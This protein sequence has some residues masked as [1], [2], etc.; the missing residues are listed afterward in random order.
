MITYTDTDS[1]TMLANMYQNGKESLEKAIHKEI[2]KIFNIEPPD[3]INIYV[4][5]WDDEYPGVHM[6]KP[7]EDILNLYEKI[8]QPDINKEIYICGEAYSKKQ[9]W[10]EGALQTSYDVLKRLYFEDIHIE[11]PHKD[12]DINKINE[13]IIHI[14]KLLQN[15]KWIAIE[16]GTIVKVYDIKDWISD[17]P[18][19]K[20]ILDGIKAN[21]YYKDGSGISP[22]EMIRNIG[23]FHYKSVKRNL[24]NNKNIKY[25]GLLDY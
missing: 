18:G 19:G 9:C 10:I 16:F 24:L 11:I 1:A 20:I 7:G 21:I 13:P 25:L 5:N 23:E 14:D 3:M 12:D 4:H 2:K 15:D 8:L 17:H 6:W 22:I